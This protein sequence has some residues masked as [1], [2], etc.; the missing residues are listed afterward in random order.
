M[1]KLVTPNFRIKMAENFVDTFDPS[2]NN[3]YYLYAAKSDTFPDDSNPPDISP[4]I[5]ETYIDIHDELS[6]GK[7]VTTNDVYR[8]VK[9]VMWDSGVVYDIYDH[10][11]ID[12]PYKNFFVVTSES[13]EYSVFK[14][15][16]NNSGAPSTDMPL[17]SETSPDDE[18]YR[19]NDGYV[20]KFCYS[21]SDTVFNNFSTLNFIPVVEDVNVAANAVNGA[22][23]TF[24][25]ETPGYDYNSYV[26]GTVKES[27]V[28]GNNLIMSIQ[29]E[30]QLSANTDFYKNNTFFIRSGRGAGQARTI[31]EY[32]VTGN[33]R[34]IL[35]DKEFDILPDFTS[36]FDIGP[37]V[38]ITGDGQDAVAIATV[39]STSNSIASI[40]VVNR[41]SGYTYADVTI[42]ANT[43]Y[44]DLQTNQ[45]KLPVAAKV[46]PIISPKGGHGSN[47]FDELYST[48]VVISVEFNGDEN[49]TIPY[50]N[51]F[52]KFGLLKN[53]YFA[54]T[55]LTLEDTS[56]FAD[57]QILT[58][59]LVTAEIAG[60]GA[61]GDNT[62]RLRKV[63]GQF[64]DGVSVTSSNTTNTS[65]ATSNVVAVDR[66]IGTFNQLQSLSVNVTDQGPNG[67]GF[68][69]DEVIDQ[70]ET[71]ATGI[72]YSANSTVIQV[73]NVKG[74]FGVSDDASGKVAEVFGKTSSAVA[75]VNGKV[76]G[77]LEDG[78]G[79]ILYIESMEPIS[80]SATQ[81]ER[82]KFIID[83]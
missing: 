10:T 7:R 38:R 53:P 6:F 43:G 33:E 4:S 2:E 18:Y 68:L 71:G 54:N 1:G 81:R 55:V 73:A 12:L 36:N 19:T 15:L 37:R 83:F 45:A 52:R 57:G 5:T 23:E 42:V 30:S 34:R 27:A 66:N 65:I 67:S 64:V 75:K 35:V 44:I 63:L 24:I 79:D 25:I 58:Q 26:S 74:Y 9:K 46:R 17:K 82:I 60:I 78:S 31:A 47:V 48:G 49:G 72:V 40:E 20:W 76:L 77:D 11:D 29:S 41:G 21:I 39:N 70:P 80:R 22:L 8:V 3:Y 69:E 16:D 32:I 51:D 14:C 59:G 13:S 50:Q 56:G 62:I 28:A 61:D